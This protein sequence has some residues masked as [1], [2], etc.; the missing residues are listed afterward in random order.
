ME[1][2]G[3]YLLR[4][5]GRGRGSGTWPDKVTC[6][7]GGGCCYRIPGRGGGEHLQTHTLTCHNLESAPHPPWLGE[8]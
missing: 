5:L 4:C 8:Y 7:Q 6:G 2:A 1:V 3:E